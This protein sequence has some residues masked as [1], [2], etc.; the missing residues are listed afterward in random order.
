MLKPD[1]LNDQ[2]TM[3]LVESELIRENTGYVFVI[4]GSTSMPAEL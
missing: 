4:S 1:V 2:I 3:A